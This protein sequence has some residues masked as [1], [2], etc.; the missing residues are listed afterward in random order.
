M[1]L[2]LLLFIYLMESG[3]LRGNKLVSGRQRESKNRE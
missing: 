1:T 3:G 2:K